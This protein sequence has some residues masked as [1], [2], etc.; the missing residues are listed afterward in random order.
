MEE[1]ILEKCTW[2]MIQKYL[3]KS[4][5]IVE[6]YLNDTQINIWTLLQKCVNN[7]WRTKNSKNTWSTARPISALNVPEHA[8]HGRH[9]QIQRNI[10][11]QPEIGYPLFH[12]WMPAYM[13]LVFKIFSCANALGAI[14][15]PNGR[16]FNKLIISKSK[17]WSTE[18]W[19]QGFEE[20]QREGVK[21]RTPFSGH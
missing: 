2:A 4:G 6:Q 10:P 1:T 15:G 11:L 12:F 17:E 3:K 18:N 9:L 13:K 8:N 21:W 7:T 16:V 14:L 5:T 20:R 19:G